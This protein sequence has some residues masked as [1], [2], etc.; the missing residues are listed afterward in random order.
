[1]PTGAEILIN[2]L[3]KSGVKFI[4]GIPSI[5]NIPLYEALQKEPAIRHILC[6]H[7]TT[8]CH[9]ADGFSRAVWCHKLT[10]GVPGVVMASTG[11]GTGY[12]VP[13]V[14]EAFGSSSPLLVITTNVPSDSIFKESGALHELI[15][16]DAIFR[17]IT[18]KTI[19][20]K[21]VDLIEAD[22]I[23][24]IE[25]TIAGRPGPVYLEIPTD[26]LSKPSIERNDGIS[27]VHAVDKPIHDIDKAVIRLAEAK[28][29]L[30]IAGNSALRAGLS[31]EIRILA[32]LLH[33]P[34]I[35]TSQSKGII[36]EN[37]ELSFGNAAQKGLVQEIAGTSD[38]AIAIGTRLREVDGK[39]RGLN[40][41]EL[42]HIDWDDTWVNKNFP[43]TISLTGDIRSIISVLLDKLSH[44]HIN[45]KKIWIDQLNKKKKETLIQ[46][47]ENNIELQYINAIRD[48]MPREGI[49]VTDNTQLGYW[50]EYFYPS[51]RPG[52]LIAAKGASPIGFAFPAAIG[53]KIARPEDKVIALIGDGGFLYCAQELATCVRHKVGFPLIVVND[54]AFG[55]I[56]YLQNK[57]YGRDFE[58]N[59]TNP[60]FIAL[61][62]SFG[63]N[64]VGVK[65][66]SQLHDALQEALS[67][68]EMWLIEVKAVFPEP[69]FAKY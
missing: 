45:D 3:K 28:R 48:V 63:V 2:S 54:S 11:P 14:Q 35:T 53:V 46:V 50:C 31:E 44:Y 62:K 58:S 19:C 60:D 22:T 8:A 49:L 4:F 24:A 65:S 61:A 66:P 59:L 56:R 39:R 38:L 68:E 36:E 51:Y 7:E 13:A 23:N 25:S 27:P 20:V 67:S 6:R 18:K 1:M 47:N 9:M 41:P 10:D 69:A 57:A 55:V 33:S 32:D 5:H 40:L 16:Q 15:S 26:I 29:P 42:I 52:G 21:S 37:N 30:I 34:V 43:A 12:L 17:S 64:A